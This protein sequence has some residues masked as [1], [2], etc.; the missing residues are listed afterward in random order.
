M[1]G[2]PVFSGPHI[3]GGGLSAEIYFSCKVQYDRQ[4]NDSN[5][6]FRVTFL[7]DGQPLENVDLYTFKRP[8]RLEPTILAPDISLVATLTEFHLRGRLGREVCTFE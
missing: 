3:K 5:A 6:R 1:K 7:F 8:E 4:Q 2:F